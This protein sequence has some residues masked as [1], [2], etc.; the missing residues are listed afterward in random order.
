MANRI[1]EIFIAEKPVSE[2]YPQRIYRVEVSLFLFENCVRS[3]RILLQQC[4][5]GAIGRNGPR[6]ERITDSSSTLPEGY[7]LMLLHSSNK[8]HNTAQPK[9]QSVSFRFECITFKTQWLGRSVHLSPVQSSLTV[10]NVSWR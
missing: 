10:R 7:N 6:C 9:V 1:V 2:L 3:L 8:E 4:A 5:G